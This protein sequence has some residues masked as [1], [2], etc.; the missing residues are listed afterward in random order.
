[1]S[2][3]L[4]RQGGLDLEGRTL[5]DAGPLASPRCLIGVSTRTIPPGDDAPEG[6]LSRPDPFERKTR[7]G[8]EF[9]GREAGETI[10]LHLCPECARGSLTPEQLGYEPTDA[11]RRHENDPA[12]RSQM[13]PDGV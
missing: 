3:G 13:P 10:V 5:C 6:W 2:V 1:V 4:L 9:P 8:Y 12:L 11:Q 7:E